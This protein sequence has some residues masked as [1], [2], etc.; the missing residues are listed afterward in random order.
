MLHRDNPS[1]FVE[2]QP[3]TDYFQV[4]PEEI[5]Q[6]IFR[7]MD[8]KGLRA[9]WATSQFNK[10]TVETYGL[11][12]LYFAVGRPLSLTDYGSTTVMASSYGQG[13]SSHRT[14]T[15]VSA[16]E[17]FGAI[18]FRDN[19]IVLF[20]QLAQAERYRLDRSTQVYDQRFDVYY[21]T[22]IAAIYVVTVR[23]RWQLKTGTVALANNPGLG[24]REVLQV[25]T[26]HKNN[27]THVHLAAFHSPSLSQLFFSRQRLDG[28][29]DFAESINVLWDKCFAKQSG[30]LDQKVLAACVGLFTSYSQD[31]LSSIFRH[32]Q[33]NVENILIDL[34]NLKP[35]AAAIL[36]YIDA[37]IKLE[38]VNPNV[39]QNGRYFTMMYFVKEKIESLQEMQKLNEI[40]RLLRIS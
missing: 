31:F 12:S 8:N 3:A 16:D 2:N 7:N 22:D 26:T 20:D 33:T 35:D 1:S 21:T 37:L 32:Q 19:R 38:A 29:A 40:S 34:K 11:N 36:E 23:Y 15:G 4:I 27:V 10:A 17:V 39:N 5:R 9:L 14:R 28:K 30:S 18:S 24:R 25:A 6:A 13:L